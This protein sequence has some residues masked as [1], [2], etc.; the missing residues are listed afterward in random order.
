MRSWLV[1]FISV[2]EEIASIE[3]AVSKN[4]HLPEKRRPRIRNHDSDN[5]ERRNVASAYSNN[6][7]KTSYSKIHQSINKQKKNDPPPMETS[8]SSDDM[9]TIEIDDKKLN[10]L[11]NRGTA[12]Q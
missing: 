3:V 11:F 5:N 2:A 6:V 8:N 4:I 10:N 7:Q 9:Y 12:F 1:L